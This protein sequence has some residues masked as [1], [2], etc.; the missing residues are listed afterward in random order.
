MSG[1]HGVGF[2]LER[3]TAFFL[4]LECDL[5]ANRNQEII[6]ATTTNFTFNNVNELQTRKVGSA[7]QTSYGYDANGCLINDGTRTFGWDGA[8][9]LVEIEEGTN[10]VE[11]VYDGIGRRIKKISKQGSTVVREQRYI[12]CGPEICWERTTIPGVNPITKR[13]FAQG[14]KTN[15][16]V[17]YYTRDHLGSVREVTDS[18][19]NVVSRYDY[20]P[21]GRQTVVTGTTVFDI[22]YAGYWN[23]HSAG[24]I[25]NLKLNLTWYR[26]YSPELGRWLSRDPIG[27]E[28]G[29]NLYGYVENRV[30]DSIDPEGL[31]GKG[32][33]PF[34]P[35]G[36]KPP[37]WDPSWPTGVDE[38]DH[39]V[40]DPT[41]GRKY[42]PH[43]DDDGH[44]DHYDYYDENGK[45]R[46]YPE[47]SLKPWRGQKRPPKG[48]QS[49]TDPWESLPEPMPCHGAPSTLPPLP[50]FLSPKPG[51]NRPWAPVWGM[52]KPGRKYHSWN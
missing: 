11:F 14:V 39:Y 51:P 13:F 34:L 37:G 25:L 33:G 3:R 45:P 12:W 35:N 23:L 48:N 52:P 16:T 42:Y 41:T 36:R 28:G 8:Q 46:R 40:Q 26:T 29:I 18:S 6:G 20:D 15:S 2:D 22:G 31:Q 47:K 9:R 24:S 7:P 21:W 10:R 4:R 27:E 5:A 32:S 30:I 43:F 38:R 50:P 49:P 17:N 44:W 19:G 1:L